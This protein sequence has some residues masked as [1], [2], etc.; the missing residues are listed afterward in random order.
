MT[1]DLIAAAFLELLRE[2]SF[3]N[4]TV[5]ALVN[6]AGVARASFY[7]NFNT[8][9]DV[10]NYV[11]DRYIKRMLV[12]ARSVIENPTERNWRDFL[13]EYVY[14]FRN[15]DNNY[16]Q[17]RSDNM[18]LLFNNFVNKAREIKHSLIPCPSEETRLLSAKLA[19]TSGVL[20][21]WKDNGMK[22]SSEEIVNFIMKCLNSF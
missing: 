12:I 4:I 8:T 17:I 14:Y 10:M 16:I 11:L 21:D 6:R 9:S 18:A 7:R 13:F 22:E 2:E 5:S 15:T 1:K 3:I 20:L 19:L